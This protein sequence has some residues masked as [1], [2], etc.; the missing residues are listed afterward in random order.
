M[1]ADKIDRR[2]FIARL[3]GATAIATM[4]AS[5]L[6]DELEDEMLKNLEAK[7]EPAEP[8]KRAK[9]RRGGGIL[10]DSVRIPELAEL[11]EGSPARARFDS[12][13][14][15]S[16]RAADLARQMLAYSGKGPFQVEPT[17]LSELAREMCHLLESAISKKAKLELD[18][19]SSLPL[20]RADVAQLQQVVMNLII[21]AGEAIEHSNGII[22]VTT[23]L[24]DVDES[25]IE[26]SQLSSDLQPGRYVFVEVSDNGVGMPPDVA[27]RIF[28]PF[29][30]TK[31]TGRGLGLAAALL[32]GIQ[33][34]ALAQ[35]TVRTADPTSDLAL[36]PEVA[37]ARSQAAIGR[38]LGDYSFLDTDNQIVRLTEFGGFVEILEGVEGL[39]HVSEM[40]E[41]HLDK[42]E[43]RFKV[44]DEVKVKIIKM[45]PVEKKIGLT[46]KGVDSD[47][48]VAPIESYR[49]EPARAGATFAD[50]QSAAVLKQP[51][52]E[53]G[54]TAPAEEATAE[55]GGETDAAPESDAQENED[56]GEE[57]AKQE[58]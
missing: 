52:A 12:I 15:A 5:T 47:E 22:S 50:L 36:N 57:P 46:I 14:T 41:E 6:A 34:G 56:A 24:Q 21:N 26:S 54:E 37:V 27:E 3:G 1:N 8:E 40:S 58:S 55:A 28:D 9:M 11:P 48:E 44:G 20:V 17:D 42:P 2:A 16:T 32:L 4:S 30:T 33:A 23:G 29:F 43:D 45:D 49:P 51:T 7:C 38:S 18:F 13:Q 31:F 39:V 19:G 25:Y 53:Q 35:E 10:F